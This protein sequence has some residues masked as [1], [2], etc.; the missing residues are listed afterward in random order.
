MP[1]AKAFVQGPD[2]YM[3]QMRIHLPGIVDR[4]RDAVFDAAH[5]AFVNY[6]IYYFS[7]EEDLQKFVA[8]PYKYV[9]EVTDPVTRDRFRPTAGSPWRSYQGR[10]FYLESAQTATTFDTAPSDYGV[11]KP[12]MAAK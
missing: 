6:E 4:T 12:A 11:L 1:C 10:L 2:P 9:G 5:R 7:S 8:A 3:R